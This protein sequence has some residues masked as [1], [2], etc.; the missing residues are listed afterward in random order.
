[1]LSSCLDENVCID[2]CKIYFGHDA[3][4]VVSYLVDTTG[5]NP[6]YYSGRCF[7]ADDKHQSIACDCCLAWFH[8]TCLNMT[9]PP[10]ARVWI[11]RGCHDM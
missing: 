3:W 10:K 6:A 5:K 4:A 7:I 1:M 11:C 8:F 9:K 2:S